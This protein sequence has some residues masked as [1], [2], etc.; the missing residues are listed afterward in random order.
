[1]AELQVEGQV[2]LGGRGR[3]PTE[4]IAGKEAMGLAW[5]GMVGPPGTH[6]TPTTSTQLFLAFSSR[7]LQDFSDAPNLRLR[8][9]REWESLA[10][11]HKT[12]LR[13]HTACFARETLPPLPQPHIL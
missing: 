9:L 12:I 3:S 7:C 1:M 13:K 4:F 8:R 6:L 5:V 10:A 11:M 2:L